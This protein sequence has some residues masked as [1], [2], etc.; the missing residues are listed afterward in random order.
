MSQTLSIWEMDPEYE[1]RLLRQHNGQLSPYGSVCFIDNFLRLAESIDIH[2]R[3]KFC[4]DKVHHAV[5]KYS[6]M[7]V[8][9]AIYIN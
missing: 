6:I 2:L 8:L 5:Y 1:K 7:H 9:L 4:V 3:L